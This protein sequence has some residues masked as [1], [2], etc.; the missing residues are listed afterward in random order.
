VK[1]HEYIFTYTNVYNCR[2]LVFKLLS[3]FKDVGSL[4]RENEVLKGKTMCKICGQ[5]H[6]NVVFR[7]CTF[8]V[9]GITGELFV[10]LRLVKLSRFDRGVIRLEVSYTVYYNYLL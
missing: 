9:S 5:R 7:P 4:A 8:N 6:V 2:H 1:L 10:S 3:I